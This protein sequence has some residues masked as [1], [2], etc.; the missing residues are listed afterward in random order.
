M[1]RT[2]R[3]RRAS[4]SAL[5]RWL[6]VGALLLVGLLYYRPLRT[7]V[8]THGA[9]QARQAEVARL[10]AQR[11]VLQE[12]LRYSTSEAALARAARRLGYVR[13]GEHLYIVKG[14][15]AWRARRAASLKSHA[16]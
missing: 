6:A 11:R 15:E 2:P 8:E 4:R 16:R 14:I 3:R 13:P 1:A 9:L 7:W 12:R 10:A 5:L